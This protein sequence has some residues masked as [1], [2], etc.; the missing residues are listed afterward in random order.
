MSKIYVVTDNESICGVY[1]T[2]EKAERASEIYDAHIREW[3]LDVLPDIPEGMKSWIVWMHMDGDAEEAYTVQYHDGL[4]H[5]D[6]RLSAIRWPG[7]KG[8]VR[9]RA[10]MFARDKEHAIKIAN[11]RR[12]AVIASGQYDAWMRKEEERKERGRLYQE[13]KGALT[14]LFLNSQKPALPDEC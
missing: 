14:A 5:E 12:I 1:S 13:P 7:E 2:R 3:E 6:V 10:C 8:G 9:L 11:E 4:D